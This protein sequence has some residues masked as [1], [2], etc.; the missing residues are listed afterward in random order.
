MHTSRLTRAPR[1]KHAERQ[2]VAAGVGRLGRGTD[3]LVVELGSNDGYMLHNVGQA[4]RGR[5]VPTLVR[6]FD[7]R[8]VHELAAPAGVDLAASAGMA[9]WPSEG[10]RSDLICGANVLAQVS[11]LNGFVRAI[12]QL[13]AP[14]G[15]LTIEFPHL[16]RF[17]AD[18]QF[19]TSYHEHLSCFSLT[20]TV[21][22]LEANR[23]YLSQNPGWEPQLG[24][25]G[26]LR[27]VPGCRSTPSTAPRTR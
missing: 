4:A 7:E 18:N 22:A 20:A 17:I 1:L 6:M 14:D 24:H 25:R 27:T 23:T 15:V 3:S 16:E 12:R 9:H 5:G 11:D 10:R 2:Y 13:Q 26:P 21:D 19:D 8:C